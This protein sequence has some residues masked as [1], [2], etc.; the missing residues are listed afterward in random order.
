[1]RPTELT[2][3]REMPPGSRL[4]EAAAGERSRRR[5]ESRSRPRVP[6]LPP[7]VHETSRPE[8]RKP[9]GSATGSVRGPLRERRADDRLERVAA[10]DCERRR[11][12]AERRRIDEERAGEDT[13]PHVA[14]EEQK[15][16]Q[17]DS[18]R[19][20]DR[21]RARMDDRDGEAEL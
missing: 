7:I 10:G 15:R 18:G 12:R 8:V 14:A 17:S 2:E 6:M 13:R 11:P 19:R 9:R 1:M 16:G 4:P 21:A 20:P 3:T 5:R